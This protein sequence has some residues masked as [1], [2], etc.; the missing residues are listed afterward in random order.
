M[1]APWHGGCLCGAVRYEIDAFEPDAAHCHCSMCRKFHGAAFATYASVARERF[2][3]VR[4][5]DALARYTAPNGTVRTFC[6]RCGSSLFFASPR[7][8]AGVVEVALGTVEGELPVVPGAHI[9]VGSGAS[10][11]R[12]HDDLPKYVQGRGRE[13]GGV[14][15]LDPGE[16][17][18]VRRML[19]LSGLPVDDLEDAHAPRFLCV[20]PP[21]R[22]NAAVAVEPLGAIGLLRSLVVDP[23]SRGQGLARALVT[24]AEERA[25]ARGM[26]AL[27]LLTTTAEAFFR[28]EGYR[29]ADRAEAPDA[30]RATREFAA[31]CPASAALMVKP[32]GR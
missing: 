18:A 5:E 11:T 8:P 2:R 15:W 28:R 22:P 7:A 6:A 27:W 1:S 17:P 25:S 4:G 16:M 30:L 9:F 13:G 10:W 31:L 26:S 14:R 23:A 20:G 32:L 3:L 29:R 12:L 19:S 24:A 21:G